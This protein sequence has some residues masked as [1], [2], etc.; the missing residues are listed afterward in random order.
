MY[1]LIPAHIGLTVYWPMPGPELSRNKV[2]ALQHWTNI[3]PI[4]VKCRDI[5]PK[6]W[7][8]SHRR[9]NMLA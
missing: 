1:L 9:P 8:E 5:Q 6:Q 4:E 2:G 7:L 3:G